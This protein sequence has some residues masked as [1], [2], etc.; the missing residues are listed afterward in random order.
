MSHWPRALPSYGTPR[1]GVC[2][3]HHAA[4]LTLWATLD[5]VSER[6]WWHT[7]PD[8]DPRSERLVQPQP[9][10]ARRA[11]PWS[12]RGEAAFLLSSLRCGDT[13]GQLWCW[14]PG[15]P[16][17]DWWLDQ[18]LAWHDAQS[19]QAILRAPGG[20]LSLW[21][22]AQDQPQELRPLPCQELAR[23]QRQGS[24]LPAPV[25]SPTG[26]IMAL[27]RSGGHLTLCDLGSGHA[28][29]SLL[30]QH[31]IQRALFLRDGS[32][33]ALDTEGALHLLDPSGHHTGSLLPPPGFTPNPETLTPLRHQAR[34][35]APCEEGGCLI[36]DLQRQELVHVVEPF[37]HPSGLEEG[38]A[39]LIAPQEAQ[40]RAWLCPMNHRAL[41][42]DLEQGRWLGALETL[43]PLLTLRVSGQLLLAGDHQGAVSW[44]GL[45]GWAEAPPAAP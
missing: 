26:Q 39:S 12:W 23:A 17:P 21:S 7:A 11:L 6:S 31:E 2:A 41:C 5:K 4:G 43:E 14:R 27:V 32:L 24:L 25:L 22:L 34:L 3:L 16:Y 20:E 35:L 1:G 30:P 29:P 8:L 18:E 36:W 13:L 19:R 10:R 37:T 33:L 9:G 38:V 44:I 42:L 40:G 28:S 45:T 15:R